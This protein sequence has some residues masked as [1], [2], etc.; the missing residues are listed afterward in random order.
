MIN[1]LRISL[2]ENSKATDNLLKR[3]T[4]F[5]I[6]VTLALALIKLVLPYIFGIN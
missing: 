2:D 1:S 3:L 5:G 4:N 6:G